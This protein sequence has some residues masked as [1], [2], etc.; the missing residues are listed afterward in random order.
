VPIEELIIRRGQLKDAVTLAAYN[1]RMAMETENKRLDPYGVSSGVK[2]VLQD[3]TKG[4][5]F[6]ADLDGRVI[7]Q[8]MVTFEWSDWRNGNIW[9]VQSVYVH[10]EFRKAGVF[11]QLLAHTLSAAQA[12]E[13]VMLRL[14]VERDNEA[15]LGTYAKLGLADAGYRVMEMPIARA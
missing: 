4:F 13:A 8:L 2:A 15:A 6:V 5:Y 10:P 3:E 11:R 14:Y 7:G 1:I 12:A 9:W